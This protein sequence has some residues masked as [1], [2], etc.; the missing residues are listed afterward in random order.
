MPALIKFMVKVQKETG[1]CFYG[2]KE[3]DQFE[4]DGL[5][6]VGGFCGAA[7]HTIFPS[8]FALRFGATFPFE[9]EE[10]VIHTT[11]PDGGKISFEIRKIEEEKGDE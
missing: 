9:K 2:Y 11:C 4:F 8:L 3:G 7:Y 10:K 5:T 1:R 6:T